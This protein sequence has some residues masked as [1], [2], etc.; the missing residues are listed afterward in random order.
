MKNIVVLSTCESC[1]EKHDQE[2][3]FQT[4]EHTNVNHDTNQAFVYALQP[5]SPMEQATDRPFHQEAGADPTEGNALLTNQGDAQTERGSA[6]KGVTKTKEKVKANR[7]RGRSRTAQVFL[8][9]GCLTGS[10]IREDLAKKLN[11]KHTFFV[12]QITRVCGA[13]GGCELS[14]RKLHVFIEMACCN[15]IKKFEVELKVVKRLPYD[16]M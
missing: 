13:F 4:T 10:Y 11:E 9:S 5:P 2:W 8:D 12:P 16:I 6:T 7:D 14:T 15:L 1:Q 3:I